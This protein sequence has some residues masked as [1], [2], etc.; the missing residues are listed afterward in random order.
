V[1][2]VSVTQPPT[3][4]PWR[5]FAPV[6]IPVTSVVPDGPPQQFHWRNRVHAIKRSWGPERLE[7]GWWRGE[8]TT[9]DYYRVETDSGFHAWLFRCLASDHWFLHGW[10]E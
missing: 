9:R 6:H 3:I 10:F 5:M 4:R 2:E 1:S 7:T 8:P